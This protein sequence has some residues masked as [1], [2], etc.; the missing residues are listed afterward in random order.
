MAIPI[1]PYGDGCDGCDDT[2]RSGGGR[3]TVTIVTIVTALRSRSPASIFL[4]IIAED[5]S[6]HLVLLAMVKIDTSGEEHIVV[7]ACHL[8][9]EFVGCDAVVIYLI[10][11]LGS[12]A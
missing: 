5:D 10:E 8:L 9:H 3:R 4:R 1:E 11:Q 2:A 6:S 12:T 7:V